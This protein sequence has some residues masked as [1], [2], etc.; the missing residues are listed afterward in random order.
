MPNKETFWNVK[1][2]GYS[3]VILQLN[4][5]LIKADKIKQIFKKIKQLHTELNILRLSSV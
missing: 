1:K 4:S 3:T 2:T 5:K